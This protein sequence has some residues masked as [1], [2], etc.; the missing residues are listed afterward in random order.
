MK[1]VG[2]YTLTKHKAIIPLDI[3]TVAKNEAKGKESDA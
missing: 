2:F 3:F 1:L